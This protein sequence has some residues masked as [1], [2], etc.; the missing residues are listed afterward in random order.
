MFTR[1]L[2]PDLCFQSVQDLPVCA[3][4]VTQFQAQFTIGYRL[5]HVFFD[6][7]AIVYLFKYISN[8]YNNGGHDASI[9]DPVYLPKVSVI[10]SDADSFDSLDAFCQ[11]PPLA[12]SFKDEKDLSFLPV[13]EVGLRINLDVLATC[14]SDMPGLSTNDFVNSLLMKSLVAFNASADPDQC[15]RLLFA[16]NMRTPLG[17]DENVM[18]DYVHLECLLSTPQKATL[19]S[20][21]ELALENRAVLRTSRMEDFIYEVI[22]LREAKKFLGKVQPTDFWSDRHTALVTNWTS[23]AYEDVVFGENAA[24]EVLMPK[25]PLLGRY[26]M[27]TCV[28]NKW[29]NGE[30]LKV[31]AVNSTY[32]ELINCVRQCASESQGLFTLINL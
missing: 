12:F 22:W 8:V 15:L 29:N 21:M 31:V 4:R 7:S 30:K 9:P 28:L 18:G 19:M 13:E 1:S 11:H 20:L 2:R 23:F 10:P 24:L 14:K 25:Q 26:A 17:Y 16:R 6:Q 3:F 32:P 27:W 5:N